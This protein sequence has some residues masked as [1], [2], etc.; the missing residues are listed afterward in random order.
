MLRRR[1]AGC[2]SPS[3][4]IA[5]GNQRGID[6]VEHDRAIHHALL[7][8]RAAREVVHH[9][10]ED[11]FE[12][13]A[14]PTGPRGAQQGL[15]GD[16][17]QGVLGELQLDVVEHEGPLV[18]AYE[19]VLRLN[20]DTDE[21]VF[22]EVAHRAHHRQPT[23][24]L[25]DQAELDEV[26]GQDVAQDFGVVALGA[27]GDLGAKADALAPDAALD[28]LVEPGERAAADEEDVRRVDL[29]ELLVRVLAPPWGGTEAVVPSRILSSACWTPSPDTSRVIDGFSDLRAILSISSM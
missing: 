1:R 24:E 12:D 13:R 2:G 3:G 27:V 25:G 16:G 23:D 29:D 6:P 9:V 14:E 10:Q 18:L 26:L 4:R 15:L 17:L 11:L 20:Q 22:V 8:I 21:G 28:D 19:R 7:H 5:D